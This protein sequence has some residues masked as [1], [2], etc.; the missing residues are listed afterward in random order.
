MTMKDTVMNEKDN[1]IV[2][3]VMCVALAILFVGLSYPAIYSH[4]E[5]FSENENYQFFPIHFTN[6]NV[7]VFSDDDF[8]DRIQT[9]LVDCTENVSSFTER[10]P[11][12]GDIVF[13]D[14]AWLIETEGEWL[15]DEMLKAMIFGEMILLFVD[16][17][18]YFYFHS[19]IE[20]LS[21]SYSV[22][23]VGDMYGV[24]YPKNGPTCHYEIVGS[25]W[26]HKVCESYMWAADVKAKFGA[27]CESLT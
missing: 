11:V 6:D 12:K 19:G 23:K 10:M 22:G 20:L 24:Y 3:F 5:N 2:I 7:V 14:E 13:I 25:S 1:F 15:T 9:T 18:Y 16:G 21:Y 17:D 4:S 27:D 26:S 8:F